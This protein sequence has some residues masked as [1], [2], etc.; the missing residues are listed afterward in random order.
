MVA[1]KPG[2][3]A[4]N[5]RRRSKDRDR[6][7]LGRV[8]RLTW[9]FFEEVVSP[10]DHWLVPDNYQ[11]GRS[12]PIAHRS[13]PTNI[14]LQLLAILSARDLGYISTPQCLSQLERVIG[15]VQKLPRYRGHLFNWYDTQTLAP[16]P[17]V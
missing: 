15:S 9:R 10:G 12:D 17:H 8:A 16:P 5:G 11:E 14:G 7:E 4:W 2:S 13:S 1:M 3:R 6:R